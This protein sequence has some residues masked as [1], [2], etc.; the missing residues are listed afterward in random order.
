MLTESAALF[1]LEIHQRQGMLFPAI[2]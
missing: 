2:M 1:Q